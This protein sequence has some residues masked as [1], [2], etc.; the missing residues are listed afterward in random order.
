VCRVLWDSQEYDGGTAAWHDAMLKDVEGV[1]QG[2]GVL[3]LVAQAGV[4]VF[5]RACVA[6]HWCWQCS[7]CQWG[8]IMGISA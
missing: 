1:Q 5:G 6:G 2:G 3:M 7:T 4:L 8:A